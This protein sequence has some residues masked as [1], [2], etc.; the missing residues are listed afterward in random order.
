MVMMQK[1]NNY[2]NNCQKGYI[3]KWLNRHRYCRKLNNLLEQLCQKGRKIDYDLTK[4]CYL[5]IILLAKKKKNLQIYFK[6]RINIAQTNYKIGFDLWKRIPN[7][8][9]AR[10][11]LQL[12]SFLRMKLD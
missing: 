10:G 6:K 5:K 3:T 12:L 1:M 8:K 2:Y 9:K 7:I 11:K 4:Q